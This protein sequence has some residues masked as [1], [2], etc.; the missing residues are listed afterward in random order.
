MA[1]FLQ[2]FHKTMN[3]KILT[4]ATILF[5]S[6]ICFSQEGAVTIHKD[7]RIEQLIKKEGE[8]VSP[9]NAPQMTGYRIQ[10]FFDDSKTKVDEARSKFMSSFPKIDSYIVYKSPNYFL[11][12][13]DFR[14]QL[15][16]E[17][18]KATLE[19]EFP[20]AFIIKETI[21]LPRIDQ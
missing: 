13:G 21:N 12:V 9:A 10:L 17:K 4:S 2:T 1:Q 14:T 6:S 18:V 20:T 3:M 5:L 15:E 16:A 19:A 7:A 11:K 8:I